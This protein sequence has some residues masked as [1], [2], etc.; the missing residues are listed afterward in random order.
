[1]LP[2][3]R[4]FCGVALST[5]IMRI[6]LL[7]MSAMYSVSSPDTRVMNSDFGWSRATDRTAP[8]G[9]PSVLRQAFV[10]FGL[11]WPVPA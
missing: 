4:M 7:P 9:V 6:W 5:S 10:L 3:T 8:S 1:M 2:A 11:R